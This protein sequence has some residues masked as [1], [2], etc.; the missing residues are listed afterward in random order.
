[1]IPE[2]F[3]T[4]RRGTLVPRDQFAADLPGDRFDRRDLVCYHIPS[5]RLKVLSRPGGAL[6]AGHNCRDEM[7]LGYARG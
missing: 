6:S 2:L 3:A 4:P 7:V 5:V 1:M